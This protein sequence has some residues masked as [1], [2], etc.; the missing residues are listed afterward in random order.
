MPDKPEEKPEEYVRFEALLRQVVKPDPK[1]PKPDPKP[2]K[3]KS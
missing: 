1:I 2:A 3:S